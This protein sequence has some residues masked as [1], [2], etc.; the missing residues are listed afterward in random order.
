M[1]PTVPPKQSAREQRKSNNQKQNV[2]K[3]VSTPECFR[4]QMDFVLLWLVRRGCL[5]RFLSIGLCLQSVLLSRMSQQIVVGPV[6]FL[7]LFFGLGTQTFVMA[8]SIRVPDI[9]QI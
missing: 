6:N 3:S 5:R 7:Q 1:V 9:D 8:E 2:S 4:L